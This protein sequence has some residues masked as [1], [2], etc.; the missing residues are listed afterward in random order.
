MA[1]LT[2]AS[3]IQRAKVIYGAAGAILTIGLLVFFCFPY[4]VAGFLFSLG[5]GAVARSAQNPG[6]IGGYALGPIFWGVGLWFSWKH[7]VAVVA[8]FLGMLAMLVAYQ[9]LRGVPLSARPGTR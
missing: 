1:I 7:F 5:L 2:G 6:K 8:L 9:R 3:V 4:L